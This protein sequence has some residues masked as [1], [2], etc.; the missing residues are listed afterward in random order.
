MDGGSGVVPA[1][2]QV[3]WVRS[4]AQ[5]LPHATGMAKAKTKKTKRNLFNFSKKT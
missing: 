4:L 1:G 3:T 5:V 2:A